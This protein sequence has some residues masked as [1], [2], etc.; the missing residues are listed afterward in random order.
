MPVVNGQ[1]VRARYTALKLRELSS[2]DRP[3]QPG[4]LATIMKRDDRTPPAEASIFALSV[5][6]YVTQDDDAHT[7]AEVLQ[8]NLFDERVW[9][10]VSALSQSIRSIIGDRSV[11]GEARDSKIGQS[12]DEFLA[13]VRDIAPDTQ[14]RL[15]ALISKKDETMK[16]VEQL[17]AEVDD[18]KAKLA[19]QMGKTT[20]AEADLV[21]A[22]TAKGEAEKAL[23]AAT[24]EVV[25][26]GDTEVRK[27]EVGATQF[28]VVK[29]LGKERDL[30]RLEKRADQEFSA[31]PGTAVEKAAVLMA[32]DGMPEPVS[33]SLNAILVAGQRLAKMGFERLG[34]H[35]ELTKAAGDFNLKVA[36]I[37]KRDG[38][39]KTAAMSKARAEFPAEFE[40]SQG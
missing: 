33:K 17:Q 31:L 35:D 19:E 9:P 29:A 3:A 25:R 27:S 21:V 20:K 15:A 30:A 37:E 38:I 39:S 16:T 22:Q 40:A 13:A 23:I 24:D 28:T 1:V 10:M 18:L 8:E 4:A 12:V 32:I 14:K 5:A 6:K 11:V 34:N 7:F 36:E 2:V 26:V